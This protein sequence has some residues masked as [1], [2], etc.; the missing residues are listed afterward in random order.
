M[1]FIITHL[2]ILLV[3]LLVTTLQT[4][5]Q[6]VG[7]A[8]NFD[9]NDD[10]IQMNS[11]LNIGTSSNTVEA[12]IKV[13][14]VGTGGLTASE[15]VG[16]VLGAHNSSPNFN[17]EI[18][19][20]GR[21]RIY[22]NSGE[23]NL[24][25]PASSDIRDNK[26]HHIAYVR[27]L[28]VNEFRLYVD[29]IEV[30]R[31]NSSGSN[32][33]MTVPHRIGCDNRSPERHF[34]HGD[35]DE[36]RIWNYART[37]VEIR[38]SMCSS[39]PPT[40]AG[41]EHYLK[42]EGTDTLV[43]DEVT[44]QNIGV[45]RNFSNTGNASNRVNSGAPVGSAS[46]HNYDI[47]NTPITNLTSAN[48]GGIEVSNVTGNVGGIH[49]YRADYPPNF[50]NNTIQNISNNNVF[51]GVFLANPDTVTYDV[52]YDYNN[53]LEV[54]NPQEQLTILLSRNNASETSWV[55]G[56][57]SLD[58]AGKFL[59]EPN[60][61]ERAEF[62]LGQGQLFIPTYSINEINNVN[63]QGEADSA[64]ILCRTKGI[65]LGNNLNFGAGYEFTLW[66]NEG[67]GVFNTID[68]NNYTVNEGDSIEITG[69]VGQDNG[70]IRLQNINDIT[71]IN[72]GNP[73]P[74]PQ[75]PLALNQSTNST[76]VSFNNLEIISDLGS[77]HYQALYEQDTLTIYIHP[78]TNV[79][80]STTLV[81]GDS[82][83]TI[84]GIG[85][86]NDP[87][88]PYNTGFR[89][90]P[91]YFADLD[92]TCGKAPPPPVLP[93]AFLFDGQ[94]DFI[95]LPDTLTIGNQSFTF[96]TW[97][98][99]PRIGSGN[100][101]PGERVGIILGSY[102]SRGSTDFNLEIFS[103]GAPRLWWNNG[104][105]NITADDRFDVRDNSWHHLA[106]VRDIDADSFNVYLD[107]E[108]II[109][110]GTVG[111]DVVGSL[112]HRIGG[113]NRNASGGPSF[114]G[115]LDEIRIWDKARTHLEIR[116][117]MCSHTPVH[118]PGLLHYYKLDSNN[119]NDLAG[120]L[121]GQEQNISSSSGY[122]L[123]DAPIGDTSVYAHPDDFALENITL[124]ST[125]RGFLN[126][127]N[128]TGFGDGI[129]IYRKD[130]VPFNKTGIF[131]LG[132]Q[133]VYF[134]VWVSNINGFPF[135]FDVTYDYASYPEA[136]N[137]A[138]NMNLYIRG[139]SLSNRWT[140]SGANV[141][142]NDNKIVLTGAGF[143]KE[144][145]LADFTPYPCSAISNLT[146]DSSYFEGVIISWSGGAGIQKMQYGTQGF[147]IGNG[148]VIDSV[149]SPYPLKDLDGLS[150]YDIYVGDSCSITGEI[151]WIGP[152]TVITPSQC[153][154]PSSMS[155]SSVTSTTAS[156]IVTA[157]GN[158]NQWITSRGPKGFNVNFGITQNFSGA[159][160]DLSSLNPNTEY[161][162]YIRSNCDSLTS[163]WLGPIG[164]KTLAVEEDTTNIDEFN[165]NS[166]TKI[167]IYPNPVKKTLTVEHDFS[168]PV[169]FRIINVMGVEIISSILDP[170][171]MQINL[172]QNL[173][174]GYYF[175]Q[176]LG[177]KE[178]RN[179]K[180]LKL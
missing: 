127:T 35:L 104:Q 116:S 17:Y 168:Q 141:N 112:P 106:Y 77:D 3:S 109:N 74:T 95:Q 30:E 52:T 34:L 167:K 12:W 152:L 171:S 136:V 164:F 62:I 88:S 64:G 36:M 63:A 148:T 61:T 82:L 39:I 4:Q 128:F 118:S 7:K 38:N 101:E 76:L 33:T 50:I 149:T 46:T 56:S 54:Q 43:F 165:S 175:L 86:Q 25:A 69:T 41:L 170:N 78:Q 90:I 6:G 156:F 144:Y 123:S 178:V 133:D 49:I 162:I 42:F 98:K 137:A 122:T 139:S 73:L 103:N 117:T 26:W 94:N 11:P 31:S 113:D 1:K 72:T 21:V 166:T 163:P 146:L 19:T 158:N 48:N 2:Q 99:V 60:L 134:G 129:H 67:I 151:N 59:S 9:G 111:D 84:T 161:D 83:C 91:R 14:E 150:N 65:V 153:P 125:N 102:A 132:N 138:A 20:G 45:M 107:G 44:N 105:I 51:Y 179:I 131:D 96:E 55:T 81:R 85:N 160:F 13:P 159:T 110:I 130:T 5:G 79:A 8:L 120:N 121:D 126:I 157:I 100:L 47:T 23:V 15:R 89:L 147:D 37:E 135:N 24:V 29:G 80:D 155:L 18:T 87:N 27:D 114:H 58:T 10:Y 119:F 57:A 142:T 176:T 93:Q 97:L 92:T 75:S 154:A 174:S 145:I 115:S 28:S 53:F 22:W 32:I 169:K 173:P 70:L 16:I 172:P 40:T 108:R 66:D 180:F 177:E 143:N 71:L 68:V 124:H 140:N